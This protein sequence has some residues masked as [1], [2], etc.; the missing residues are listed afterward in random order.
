MP[1]DRR[2]SNA[3]RGLRLG[4]LAYL[5]TVNG[6]VSI[7][8]YEKFLSAFKNGEI[9]RLV[10]VPSLSDRLSASGRSVSQS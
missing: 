7:K 4:D 8:N 9:K 3:I 10:V 2:R 1:P 6:C 5:R